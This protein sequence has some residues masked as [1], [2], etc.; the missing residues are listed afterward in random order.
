[1]R[2]ARTKDQAARTK[3]HELLLG[4]IAVFVLVRLW[5]LLVCVK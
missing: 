4:E 2:G 5:P 1:M 3:E